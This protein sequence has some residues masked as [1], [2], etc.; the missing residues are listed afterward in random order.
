MLERSGSLF[1][2]RFKNPIEKEKLALA[3]LEHCLLGRILR[4]EM[5]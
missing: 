5:L 4:G 1:D 3:Q 2:E